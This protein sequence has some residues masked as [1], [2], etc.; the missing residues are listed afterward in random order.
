MVFPDYAISYDNIKVIDSY[1]VSKKVFDPFL[2]S[3]RIKYQDNPVL[4]NRDNKSMDREW[5]VHNL[6]YKWNVKR[7]HSKDVDLNYPQKWYITLMYNVLGF[8]AMW[9]ID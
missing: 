1:K 7:D 9:F 2:N 5:A 6:A 4:V 3:L 8:F